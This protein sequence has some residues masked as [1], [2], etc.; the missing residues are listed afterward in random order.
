MARVRLV[1]F[2]SIL[3]TSMLNVTGSMS[4]NTGTASEY[5]GAIAVAT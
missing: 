1:I 4:T 5:R 2:S 3:V